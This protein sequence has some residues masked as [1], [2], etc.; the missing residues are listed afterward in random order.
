M[1]RRKSIGLEQFYTPLS[2]AKWAVQ[3]LK[4]QPWWFD[5][6]EAIEPTAG[7]GAFVEALK[8]QAHYMTVH[9]FDLEPK[10][11]DVI[12]QD[13]LTVDVPK[14]LWHERQQQQIPRQHV[15]L[16]GNPPFG[17]R[18]K[19]ARQIWD[20]YADHVGYSAFIVPRAMSIPREYATGNCIPNSHDLLT[21]LSLPS[22]EFELPD[23]KTKIVYGCALLITRHK[24]L[25]R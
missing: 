15:L 24:S 3:I 7:M 8:P 21:A 13:T 22:E 10:H 16:I 1:R 14:L 4:D 12:Q 5:I 20:H 18:A 2:T 25:Y 9:A 23:G 11:P 19:L 17:A 6:V